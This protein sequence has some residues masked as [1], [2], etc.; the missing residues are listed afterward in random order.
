MIA[1]DKLYVS[2]LI[3]DTWQYTTPDPDDETEV[4]YVRKNV[5]LEWAKE[6]YEDYDRLLVGFPDDGAYWSQRNAFQQMIDKL[7]SM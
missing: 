2:H 4:E 3:Y 1:P 7:N 5:L 6:K